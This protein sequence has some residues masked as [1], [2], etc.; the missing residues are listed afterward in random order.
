MA[1]IALI[2]PNFLLREEFGDISDPPIGIASIA[3]WLERHGHEIMIIDAMAENIGLGEVASRLQAFAPVAVGISCNYCPLHNQT[4]LLAA[5]I[6]QQLGNRVTVFVGGNH[7]SAMADNLLRGAAGNIDVIV[8]GEGELTALNLIT[9]LEAKAPLSQVAGL[10]YLESGSVRRTPPQAM[11][12]DIDSLGMPAYHLLPMH[13]YRRYN[14][15]SMRGCPYS[16]SYCASTAIFSRKVRYRSPESVVAEIEHLLKT[17]GPRQFWFS[18]DTFTVNRTHTTTMLR[19]MVERTGGISWSCLTT[20]NS[21]KADLLELMRDSGCEYI[22]YG[23]ESGNP[24]TLAAIGKK[25]T[26]A[27]IAATSRLTHSVGLR[28]YGFFIFG[29]VDETWDSVYDTYKLIHECELDGGG[30]NILIPLPGTRMW[31]TLVHERGAFTPDEILWDELFARLPNENRI[32]YAAELAARWTRMSAPDLLEACRIGQRMFDISRHL[33][34]GRIE[35]IPADAALA[36]ST[37]TQTG[38]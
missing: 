25:T 22:S 3:A 8:T 2:V 33:K 21:V 13:L 4:L 12:E 36:I 15:V 5:K 28:H 27:S 30:M 37:N 18:D 35:Q 24:D 16:C 1:K 20:V 14:I 6:K 34:G 17:Y 23:V 10:A 9:A 31:T 29:F 26:P 11:V 38:A 19:S 7:A 32:P